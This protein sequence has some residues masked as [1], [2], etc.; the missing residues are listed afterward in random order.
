MMASAVVMDCKTRQK[1]HHAQLWFTERFAP[2]IRMC[3]IKLRIVYA[4]G[5]FTQSHLSDIA[6]LT[7]FCL[8][9]FLCCFSLRIRQG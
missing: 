7:C 8:G 3:N 2:E 5:I 6:K 9:I 1:N 4:Y